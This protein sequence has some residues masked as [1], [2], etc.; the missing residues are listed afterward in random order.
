VHAFA[1]VHDTPASE[2]TLAP[3]GVAVVWTVQLVPFQ[4]SANITTAPKLLVDSPTAMHA[5]AAPHDTP[6][7]WPF[8]TTG[9]GVGTADQLAADATAGTTQNTTTNA[10]TT[11][12]TRVTADPSPR[13]KAGRFIAPCRPSTHA[14]GPRRQFSGH[15]ASSRPSLLLGKADPAR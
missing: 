8:A 5:L 13:P 2:L 3:A 12:P 4:S 1:F 7:T 6:D 11:R 14:P 10:T 9:F 15:T